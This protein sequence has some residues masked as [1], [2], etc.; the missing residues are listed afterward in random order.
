[1]CQ[2]GG[3]LRWA[4]GRRTP[5]RSSWSQ[6]GGALAW[7]FI[8][9][10][11]L[12]FHVQSSMVKNTRIICPPNLRLTSLRAC[13][14]KGCLGGFRVWLVGRWCCLFGR[15]FFLSALAGRV[16]FAA[17]SV[18]SLRS[19]VAASLAGRVGFAAP[20]AFALFVVASLRFFVCFL[21]GF[22]LVFSLFL[23][24]FVVGGGGAWRLG[25]PL[26]FSGRCLFLFACGSFCCF[27]RWFPFSCFV[28]P[29]CGC[30]WWLSPGRLCPCRS[31]CG[32]GWLFPRSLFVRG[33]W[34]RCGWS[35][36]GCCCF[37][38]GLCASCLWRC[39]FGGGVVS[40]C[41]RWLLPLLP[42]VL[43]V[44]GSWGAV[45]VSVLG[46]SLP[47][48]CRSVFLF[49]CGFFSSSS[50]FF[51]LVCCFLGRLW[52]LPCAFAFLPACR[53]V[54]RVCLVG[55]LLPFFLCLCLLWSWRSLVGCCCL[56][57][58]AWFFF[59][60]LRRCPCFRW[61]CCP[62]PSGCCL[63][64]CRGCCSFALV[65]LLPRCPCSCRRGWVCPSPFVG[66]LWFWFFLGGGAVPWAWRSCSPVPSCSR[67]SACRLVAPSAWCFSRWSL[68]LVA[69]SAAACPF[70]FRVGL[71]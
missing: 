61:S 12:S 57:A 41:W 40:F 33:S 68:V 15:S 44:V 3:A 37:L 64:S 27:L 21:F 62:S 46:R 38:L 6:R 17:P 30:S 53:L 67:C 47:V 22:C 24:I 50:C 8:G 16:G 42:L 2:G 14:E 45:G 11:I 56:W 28:V 13:E 60:L 55:A 5:P 39:C 9:I 58:W 4:M 29:S 54:L 52:W 1:V 7:Q 35:S 32:G 19:L 49:A 51:A 70:P 31:C 65:C 69:C 66:V 48:S 43:A 59:V 20:S 63:V 34:V 25:F 10:Q 18:G 26:P 36:V 71:S 23:C